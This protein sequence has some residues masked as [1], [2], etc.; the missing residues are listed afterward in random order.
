MF[1]PVVLLAKGDRLELAPLYLGSLYARL[2]ECSRSVF[3]SVDRYN[4]VSYV[5]ASFLQ[6]FMWE[7]FGA[8]TLML[9]KLELIKPEKVI[10]EGAEREKTSYHK[11]RG[12]MWSKVKL[13]EVR[14]TS[15]PAD[16]H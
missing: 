14:K 3:R 9:V 10:M 11:P 1:P 4:V 8:F 16:R 15:E 2:D 6:M 7:S 12:L 13:E 5:N